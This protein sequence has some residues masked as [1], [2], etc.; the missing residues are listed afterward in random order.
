MRSMPSISK[1][2]TP[3][4]FTRAVEY[5]GLPDDPA[6][7]RTTNVTSSQATSGNTGVSAITQRRR[8]RETRTFFSWLLHHD[9][10]SSDSLMNVKNMLPEA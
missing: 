5:L 4:V 10:I 6:E 7:F 1:F 9:Y 2:E 3:K 8:Q